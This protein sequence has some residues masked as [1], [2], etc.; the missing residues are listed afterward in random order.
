MLPPPNKITNEQLNAVQEHLASL[1][2]YESH[3]CRKETSKKY[4]PPHFTVTKTYN[5]Y[6]ETTEKPISYTK[7]LEL[8]K[9]S[10]IAKVPRKILA[11]PAI[12]TRVIQKVRLQYLC[13][14]EKCL[15]SIEIHRI[16][17]KYIKLSFN[18]IAVEIETFLQS[19][20]Q[21]LYASVIDLH[22]QLFQP[23]P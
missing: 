1:P 19:G 16:L 17:H 23:L 6:C 5:M 11:K 2:A 20:H 10:N 18:V 9:K 12:N 8:F 13:R 3:Y 7:Y 15:Y 22:R 14:I 4:L 21:L